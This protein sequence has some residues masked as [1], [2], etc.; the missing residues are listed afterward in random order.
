[1]K[2][3]NFLTVDQIITIQKSTLTNSGS[4]DIGKLEGALSRI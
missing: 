4:P 2:E 1:M 3:I